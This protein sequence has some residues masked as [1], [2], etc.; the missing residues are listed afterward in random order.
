M[1]L[2][3]V[4]RLAK[5]NGD[6]KYQS[7]IACPSGH[8]GLRYTSNQ[9]CCE[10]MAIAVV[11]RRMS[12]SPEE[13]AKLR[14]RSKEQ[15][16]KA[17]AEKRAAAAPLR[18]AER[19]RV[20]QIQVERG[21]DLP[22]SREEAK[23]SGSTFY[24]NGKP[25][26]KGHITIR[27]T[28][29]PGCEECMPVVRKE[30]LVKR[31]EERPEDLKAAKRRHYER[32]AEEIKAKAR[33]WGEANAEICREK[34][35]ARQKANPHIYRINGSLR[36]ARKKNATPPWVAGAVLQQIKDIYTEASKLTC[37]QGLRLAVDHIVPLKHENVCGLHVPANLR[38]ATKL[39]N[40]KKNNRFD[41]QLGRECS[42]PLGCG[43]ALGSYQLL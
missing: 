9:M 28:K 25:C 22:L 30:S 18:E 24:F 37:S 39:E 29:S 13:T 2:N 26:P 40:S 17:A 19:N 34:A 16:R 38:L 35:K 11:E 15:K 21:L 31:R 5:Q 6:L 42:I 33:A 4:Y 7:T 43:Y 36:R 23:V 3:E 27:R 14:A 20:K 41:E 32:H 1:H 8:L 12:M 10:C